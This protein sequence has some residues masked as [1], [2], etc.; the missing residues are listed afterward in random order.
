MSQ[1]KKNNAELDAGGLPIRQR[2]PI[3]DSGVSMPRALFARLDRIVKLVELR[4]RGELLMVSLTI[5]LDMCETRAKR[6]LPDVV[7]RYDKNRP[8]KEDSPKISAASRSQRCG[9][10]FSRTLEE[11]IA[12]ITKPIGWSRNQFI[13]E[14]AKTIV[15]WCEDPSTRTIPLVVLLYETA[16]APAVPLKLKHKQGLS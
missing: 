2:K 16:L 8:T 1:P 12:T 10:H 6:Y 11:R 3:H 13:M 4:S 9:T 15:Q 5:V 14:A 7:L